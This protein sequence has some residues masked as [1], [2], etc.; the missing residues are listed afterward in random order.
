MPNCGSQCWLCDL[1]IRFDTYKGCTHDCKYCFVRRKTGLEVELGETIKALIP[2]IQGKRTKETAWCDWDIPIHWGGMS[3]P[4]QPCEKKYKRSLDALEVFAQTGY[5]VIISTKGRLCIE[6]P[7]I[8]LLSKANV[9]MQVSALCSKYDEL[10]KGAPPFNER[11]QMINILSKNVKRVI[12]RAQ[13]YI[14]DIYNDMLDNIPKFAEAGAY[15]IIFEGMKFAKKK[16]GLVK[17]GAD[18]VQ[19]KAL[20]KRDFDKLKEQCHKFGLKFYCGENR[21]RAMG[22][23]LTCCGIDGLDGFVPNTFNLSHLINGDI[24][25]AKE[26]M[27]QK[28]TADAFTAIYQTTSMSRYIREHSFEDMVRFIYENR[29][30]YV[31]SVLIKGIGE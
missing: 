4:F 25:R 21:L 22:D 5:P 26:S 29:K 16:P 3:D 8:S 19:K 12:V 20:L 24:S 18:F 27:K 15:G 6:E 1:P 17:S 11:L 13:P 28:G 14:H 2:F 30:D 23:S 9:V 7:Y 10:E 31:N